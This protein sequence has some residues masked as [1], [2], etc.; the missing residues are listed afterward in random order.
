MDSYIFL[1]LFNLLVLLKVIAL[2][3][4]DDNYSTIKV[5]DWESL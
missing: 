5:L 1:L 4:V 3:Y 2:L